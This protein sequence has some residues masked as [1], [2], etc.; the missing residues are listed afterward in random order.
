MKFADFQNPT[1]AELREWARDSGASYPDEMQQDWD[2]CVADWSRVDLIA[3]LAADQ[4]CPTRGFF[5]SVLYL[6]AGDCVR[7]PSGNVNIPNLRALLGRL[8]NSPSEPLRLFRTRA[9]ALLADPSTFNYEKWCWGDYAYGRDTAAPSSGSRPRTRMKGV[10]L[11][12][13]ILFLLLLVG[14]V[15]YAIVGAVNLIR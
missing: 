13:L 6:M 14:A 3:E 7:Y 12:I 5:L 11:A 8:D 4:S 15:V 2:L 1:E 9:L 10:A